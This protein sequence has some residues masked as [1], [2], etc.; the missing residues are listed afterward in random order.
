M[1]HLRVRGIG[2][3]MCLI[4]PSSLIDIQ[5]VNRWQKTSAWLSSP[6][7]SS[8]RRGTQA[9]PKAIWLAK[10]ALLA[11]SGFDQKTLHH[12]IRWNSEGWFPT[13]TLG[14]HMYVHITHVPISIHIC[15]HIQKHAYTNMHNAIH[16]HTEK[17]REEKGEGERSRREKEKENS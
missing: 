10:L 1:A 8:L 15:T 5:V 17:K 11:N 16:T 12:W 7:D 13:L 9:I 3:P 6:R 4:R 14:L 2:K